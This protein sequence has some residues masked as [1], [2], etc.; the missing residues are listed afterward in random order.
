MSHLTVML[1]TPAVTGTIAPF[2]TAKSVVT[3]LITLANG[4]VT[5]NGYAL[6]SP[7][8]VGAVTVMLKF[9]A[10]ASAGMLQTLNTAKLLTAVSA[11]AG[12][13]KGPLGLRVSITR[14]GA[15]V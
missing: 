15:S 13:T 12:P 4:S 9:T 11:S 3:Q 6:K 2:A 10:F 8:S 1:F 5:P 14:L 7:K